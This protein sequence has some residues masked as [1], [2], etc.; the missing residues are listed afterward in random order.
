MWDR[1]KINGSVFFPCVWEKTKHRDEYGLLHQSHGQ[2]TDNF[3]Y[4]VKYRLMERNV[5]H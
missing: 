2:S 4:I 3:P 5:N 1:T